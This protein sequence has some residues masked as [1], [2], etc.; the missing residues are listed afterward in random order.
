[1]WRIDFTNE[2]AK[3]YYINM[4]DYEGH[5]PWHTRYNLICCSL[6]QKWKFEYLCCYFFRVYI[7]AI[8]FPMK[9]KIKC[10]YLGTIIL[11]I[12]TSKQLR[13]RCIEICISNT[14]FQSDQKWLE[15]SHLAYFPNTKSKSLIHTEAKGMF[16]GQIVDDDN[17][18]FI[19]SN[20]SLNVAV[21]VLI[22]E[23]TIL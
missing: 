7:L 9:L 21:N 8:P 22:S 18:S 13:Q 12:W 16:N 1:M 6:K 15:N 2:H 4:F 20:V 10:V 19:V 23:N 14:H 5:N 11:E 3:N 17:L